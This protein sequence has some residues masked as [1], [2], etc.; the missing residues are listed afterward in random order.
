MTTGGMMF[1]LTYTGSGVL[2]F[3]DGVLQD[4]VQWDGALFYSDSVN[5]GYVASNGFHFDGEIA[6]IE[7][8][9]HSNIISPEGI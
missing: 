8:L 6:D 9:G 2:L 5:I 4:S 1:F 7:I 3:V